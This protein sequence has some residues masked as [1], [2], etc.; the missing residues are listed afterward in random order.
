[1]TKQEFTRK[2]KQ[3]IKWTEQQRDFIEVAYLSGLCT[4]EEKNK[5]LDE[6]TSDSA[7]QLADLWG[8]YDNQEVLAR[9]SL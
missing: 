2:S 4:L 8:F 5:G 6:L 9:E 3:I 1:M 7:K